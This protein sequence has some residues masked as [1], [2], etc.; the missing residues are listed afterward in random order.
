VKEMDTKRKTVV[1]GAPMVLLFMLVTIIA[2]WSWEALGADGGGTTSTG[3]LSWNV[4]YWHRASD[5]TVIGHQKQHNAM[6][7]IGMEEAMLRLIKDGELS[8]GDADI[9]DQIVLMNADDSA[10]DGLLAANILLDV[11]GT[12]NP[13]EVES[14]P[15]DGVFTDVGT[16]TDGDG[17]VTVTFL[18][19]GDPQ[20]ATQMHLVKSA[21]DDTADGGVAAVAAED[22]A[23]TIEISVDLSDTDTLQVDW[24][25][26]LSTE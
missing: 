22:I 5:G 2:L 8:A 15:A 3:A 17:K 25:I 26:N 4:E 18:A 19:Q 10:D 16:A 7:G 24:T 9:F 12:N 6:T 11:D 23:A 14:N 13:D 21:P 20:P 1:F